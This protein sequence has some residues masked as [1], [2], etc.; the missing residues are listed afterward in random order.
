MLMFQVYY[1]ALLFSP[2]GERIEAQSVSF[3]TALRNTIQLASD[4]QLTHKIAR[5]GDTV[6][7]VSNYELTRSKIQ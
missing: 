4:R 1:V 6:R 5:S 2:R 3:R 7:M